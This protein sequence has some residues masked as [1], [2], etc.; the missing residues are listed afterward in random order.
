VT[1]LTVAQ[2]PFGFATGFRTGLGAGFTIGFATGSGMSV[3]RLGFMDFFFER[4]LLPAGNSGPR[5]NDLGPPIEAE[6]LVRL[7]N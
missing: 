3:P 2:V 6:E 7:L 1:I 5:N 4:V